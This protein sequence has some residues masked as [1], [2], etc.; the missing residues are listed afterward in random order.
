MDHEQDRDEFLLSWYYMVEKASFRWASRQL[1]G[2]NLS[3]RQLPLLS[4]QPDTAFPPAS[5]RLMALTNG[6]Q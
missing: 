1:H 6:K 2:M 4:L 3:T 5:R